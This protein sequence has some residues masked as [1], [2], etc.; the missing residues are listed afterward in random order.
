[1]FFSLAPD[2]DAGS[3][4]VITS[5]VTLAALLLYN[6][7]NNLLQRFKFTQASLVVYLSRELQQNK[8]HSGFRRVYAT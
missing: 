4:E 2:A 5:A 8:L 3:C 6:E 1:M 7:F